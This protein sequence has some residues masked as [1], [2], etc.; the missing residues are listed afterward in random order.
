MG[1]LRQDVGVSP[2]QSSRNAISAPCGRVLIGR[3]GN[4]VK[5]GA[6]ALPLG[7]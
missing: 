7:E 6:W 4:E 1:E 5:E 3:Q 2:Q